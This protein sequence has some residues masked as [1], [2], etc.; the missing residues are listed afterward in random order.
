VG[1]VHDPVWGVHVWMGDLYLCLGLHSGGVRSRIHGSN[2]LWVGVWVWF[3]V[4]FE[5]S[6]FGWG[7]CVCVWACV[8]VVFVVA[9]GVAIMDMGFIAGVRH[10]VALLST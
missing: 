8:Q 7:N 9:F 2:H 3:M 4:P 6:T 5:A 10:V 1:L